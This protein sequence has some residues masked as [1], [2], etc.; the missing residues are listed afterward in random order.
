MKG[1]GRFEMRLKLL[2]FVLILLGAI[3]LVTGCGDPISSY[4]EGFFTDKKG[5]Y[6]FVLI[7]NEGKRYKIEEEWT[8]I[9]S[10]QID[11]LKEENPSNDYLISIQDDV[12]YVE[13][14]KILKRHGMEN[15]K[16]TILVYEL[17]NVIFK[18]ASIDEYKEFVNNFTLSY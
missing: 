2:N 4:E 6:S 1:E 13:V 17:N 15:K 12:S 8:D 10:N 5:S 18:S 9:T 14:Q 7:A 11:R 16:Y 3:L